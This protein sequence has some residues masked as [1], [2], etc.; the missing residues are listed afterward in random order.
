LGNP[1]RRQPPLSSLPFSSPAA[2][3]SPLSSSALSSPPS[4]LPFLEKKNEMKH[5]S[6]I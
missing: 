1:D 3:S 2:A 6:V 5:F 4:W